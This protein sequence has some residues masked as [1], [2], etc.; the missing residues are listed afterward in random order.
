[1]TIRCLVDKEGAMEGVIYQAD[2]LEMN[3]A[4]ITVHRTGT[5]VYL[6]PTEF[7]IVPDPV[8][9]CGRTAEGVCSRCGQ[10]MG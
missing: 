4:R 8:C 6:K 3:C 2:C 7:E 5:D 1:M 9:A 10:D